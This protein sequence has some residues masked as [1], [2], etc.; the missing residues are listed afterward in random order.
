M[1][2]KLEMKNEMMEIMEAMMDEIQV[3]QELKQ[4]G[5][6]QVILMKE[7]ILESSEAQ[8]SIKIILPSQLNEC[9]DVGMGKELDQKNEIMEVLLVPMDEALT[10][11]L[12]PLDGS[13]Q[14]DPLHLQIHA[15]NE[16]LD[17][18]QTVKPI[19]QPEFLDEVMDS[20][21]VQKYETME[22][23]EVEMDV[24]LGEPKWSQVG[25]E[26]EEALQLKM[27]DTSETLVG[28]KTAT[29]IPQSE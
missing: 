19:Q 12:L 6:D 27:S 24:I 28:I 22:T 4:V 17:S 25:C 14:V 26:M 3:V 13:V 29:L 18:T 21:Q 7:E 16:Q 11:L 15:L 1:V 20:E 10:V 8:D 9:L 5:Y 2:F 23:Q